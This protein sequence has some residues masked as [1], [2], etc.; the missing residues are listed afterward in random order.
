VARA[1]TPGDFYLP[2]T[3]LR[4][5]YRPNLYARSVGGRTQVKIAGQ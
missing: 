5:M 3:E 4:D 1:V 2:G